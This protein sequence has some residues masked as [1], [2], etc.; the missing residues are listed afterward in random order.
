MLAMLTNGIEG[1]RN[2]I[3]GVSVF[4]LSRKKSTLQIHFYMYI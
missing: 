4:S 1:V 2:G 3:E